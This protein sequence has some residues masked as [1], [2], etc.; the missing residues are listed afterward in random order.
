M[1]KLIYARN[2]EQVQRQFD[3]VYQKGERRT[4]M[5]HTHSKRNLSEKRKG[6]SD[7]TLSV[8]S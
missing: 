4:P 5:A 7:C 2:V 1:Q 8:T 3:K 6:N